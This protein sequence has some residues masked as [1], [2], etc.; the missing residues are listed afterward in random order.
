MGTDSAQIS[1]ENLESLDG[2]VHPPATNLNSRV[3]RPFQEGL[4]H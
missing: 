3:I 2:S 1:K 4:T